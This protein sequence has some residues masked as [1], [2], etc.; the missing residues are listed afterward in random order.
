MKILITGSNGLLGQKL[1]IVF[2]LFLLV[3]QLTAAVHNSPDQLH[4][5]FFAFGLMFQWIG[6][7]QGFAQS[8]LGFIQSAALADQALL[9]YW[10]NQRKQQVH[11][12]MTA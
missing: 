7:V 8:L 6:Y 5:I 2:F 4:R 11:S 3:S 10:R 1:F 12:I 9:F